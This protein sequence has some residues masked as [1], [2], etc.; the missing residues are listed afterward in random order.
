MEDSHSHDN[1]SHSHGHSHDD[2]E[3][4]TKNS[5]RPPRYFTTERLVMIFVVCSYSVGFST[6]IFI[7]SQVYKN[8]EDKN[9]NAYINFFYMIMVFLSFY[10]C[11]STNIGQTAIEE[12]IALTPRKFLNVNYQKFKEKCDL[13]KTIKFERSSHCRTCKVCVLRRDHHCVFIG[14]CVGYANTQYFLNFLVWSAIGG[15]AYLESLMLFY[16]N[17]G[18]KIYI[19]TPELAFS[20]YTKILVYLTCLILIA[21]AFG[22][23]FLLF[24]QIW[25]VFN[26]VS[27]NERLKNSNLESYYLCCAAKS[28]DKKDN[29]GYNKGYLNNFI[30]VVGPSFLHFFFPFPKLNQRDITENEMGFARVKFP[31]SFEVRKT[32]NHDNSSLNMSAEEMQAAEPSNLL[33]LSLRNYGNRKIL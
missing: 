14:Q 32:L 13:C 20:I 18:N 4:Q 21:G 10:L 31:H 29:C 1:C 19:A 2:V 7:F 25:A 15:F 5:N 33:E 28:Y 22:T 6:Q 11:A 8:D 17:N 12:T 27:Y 30:N 26:E 9:A 24:T 16:N 3:K 23:S